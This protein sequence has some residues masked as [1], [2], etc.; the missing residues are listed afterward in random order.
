MN[1]VGNGIVV[2]VETLQD[3]LNVIDVLWRASMEAA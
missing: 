3:D 1:G 2:A